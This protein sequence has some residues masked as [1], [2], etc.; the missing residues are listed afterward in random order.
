MLTSFNIYLNDM[1]DSIEAD[2]FNFAND[3]NLSSVD[4][5]MDE[6]NA[7]LIS[8][9]EAALNWI[10]ANDMIANSEKSISCSFHLTNSI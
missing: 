10:E 1:L 6:A 5:T 2:L 8:E 7:L 4:H 9:T 3:N